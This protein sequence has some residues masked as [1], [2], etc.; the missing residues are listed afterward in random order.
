MNIDAAAEVAGADNDTDTL[1]GEAEEHAIDSISL[2][3]G[4]PGSTRRSCADA[5]G[6][7]G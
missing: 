2:G 1:P 4:T 5:Y 7:S 6:G 3:E